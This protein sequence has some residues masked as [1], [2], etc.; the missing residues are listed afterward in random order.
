M[1]RNIQ[2]FVRR[3]AA[4]HSH[5]NY[6]NSYVDENGYIKSEIDELKLRSIN[7]KLMNVDRCF[8]SPTA[9]PGSPLKRNI[10]FSTSELNS[11][12]SKVMPAVYDQISALKSAKNEEE[13]KEIIEKL[14]EQISVVQFSIQCSTNSLSDLI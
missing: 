12:A 3:A 13:Q 10:L 11:Y 9:I 8:V 4:F 7:D 5:Q 1:I 6:Y 14:T 2:E